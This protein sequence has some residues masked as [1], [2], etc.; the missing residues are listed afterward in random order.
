MLIK[1]TLIF[2][3][4]IIANSFLGQCKNNDLIISL[5]NYS[6][7]PTDTSYVDYIDGD[8]LSPYGFTIE[9]DSSNYS[10]LRSW[11]SYKKKIW[12]TE[13]IYNNINGITLTKI[14]DTIGNLESSGYSII[15]TYNIGIWQE[16]H[17]KELEIVDYDTIWLGP[18]FCEFIE[19]NKVELFNLQEPH[20][21]SLE[22]NGWQIIN[23][24]VLMN[25]NSSKITIIY[26]KLPY[27]GPSDCEKVNQDKYNFIYSASS[28]LSDRQFKK[29]NKKGK[30]RI[31]K[32]NGKDWF[33]QYQKSVIECIAT[34][35]QK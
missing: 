12:N 10:I 33:E 15:G 20:Y 29:L 16:Y 17:N 18:S 23:E 22:D 34:N 14:Y 13:L 3:S 6:P 27:F 19:K 25:K 7:N 9:T 30:K 21:L 24:R 35:D 1:K 32:I 31:A 4:L 11:H 26:T 8:S 5:F 2:L 28:H